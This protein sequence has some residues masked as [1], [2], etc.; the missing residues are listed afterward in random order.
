M[1]IDL[2]LLARRRC[3]NERTMWQPQSRGC[4]GHIQIDLDSWSWFSMQ[5]KYS[6]LQ[7]TGISASVPSGSVKGL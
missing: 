1:G 4:R 2:L 3:L 7:S 6:C 5:E